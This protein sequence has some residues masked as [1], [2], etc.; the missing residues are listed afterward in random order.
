M[1]DDSSCKYFIHTLNDKHFKYRNYYDTYFLPS[2]E[3][4]EYD[5]IS[6]CCRHTCV[7]FLVEAKVNQATI[8]KIVGH[9]D[10]IALTERVYTHLNPKVLVEAINKIYVP[11]F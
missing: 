2:M 7:S 6:H 1:K 10:A 3:Y 5:Q 8:K 11:K 4:F 9:S